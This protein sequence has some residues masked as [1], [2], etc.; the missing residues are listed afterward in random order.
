MDW[1]LLPKVLPNTAE[2]LGVVILKSRGF[3]PSP[4]W[5]WIGVGVLLGYVLLFNFCFSLALG[6]FNRELYILLYHVF[7]H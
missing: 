7:Y 4:S 6:F 2:P 3:F 5:Y 1:I